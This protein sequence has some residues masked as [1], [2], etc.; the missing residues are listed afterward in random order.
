M[1]LLIHLL[2]CTFGMGS[3]VAIN[4][5]WVELPLLVAELPEGWYLPSYLTVVIQLA[6]VGPLLVTLL[7]HFQP[8]CLSEVPIIFAVLAVGTLACTLFAFLWNVTS[9]VLDGHHSV[10]FMVLTFFLAL[11]DCTSSVTFLPF[12]SR[13]SARYLTTFFVGEG[14]SGLLPALVALAQGS[15]LTTCVNVTQP[16]DT[17]PST[18]TTG[19]KVFLQGANVTLMSDLTGTTQSTVHLESRYLP[20]NFSPLVF[21]L[22]L[23]FMMACCLAAFFVLQRQSRPRESSIDDLLTSQVTLHSIRPRD[24]EDLGPPDPG[25]CIKAQG[26]PEEKTDSKHPGQLAFIY[27]LVAFVNALTNGVLPSVQTYSCLSYGPVAYHLSAT[28]S[29]MANPLVCFLS[30]FLQLRSLPFL[31]ILTV[32]G[33]GFGAYNMAMAVMSPCPLMQGHWA[34]EVLIVASWV[35]FIGCLSYVKVMLGVILRDRSRSALLW[36]GAAVQLGSLLGAL[37]MFPLVNVLRLFSSADF[38]SLQCSA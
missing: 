30:M 18:E 3:W 27:I 20:A 4:G 22:L 37:L 19:K 6:N 12:M 15:G 34:G 28:L 24:G 13:L 14:L 33:T 16:S 23:S 9:W 11:V 35:L 17:T 26:H 10:A 38:C 25:A 2:V 8:G 21:F 36:C 7:H 29:S 1:A 5:L 32:L 31:G